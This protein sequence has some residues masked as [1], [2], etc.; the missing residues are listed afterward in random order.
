MQMTIL[1]AVVC[2]PADRPSDAASLNRNFATIQGCCNHWCMILN[3]NKIMGLINS[4]SRS[5]NPPKW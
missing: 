3:P 4:R 2:M 1:L 5:V